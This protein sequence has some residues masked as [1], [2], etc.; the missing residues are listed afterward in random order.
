MARHLSEKAFVDALDGAVDAA[1]RGHLREC[2][3]CAA[4]VR[5][6]EQTLRLASN[7]DV[8]EPSPLY[9]DSLRAQ[10]GRR[11]DEERPAPWWK[12]LWA[13][14]LA[15]AAAAALVMVSLVPR[16]PAPSPAARSLPAWSALPEE[17]DEALTV[18]GGLGPSDEEVE[19]LAGDRG[20]AERIADMTDDESRA[21]V[22]ALRG[23]WAGA[24]R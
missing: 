4:R 11:L 6:M 2:A 7:A 14:G 5:E 18:L 24:R 22:E 16:A 23:D 12:R 17:D 19:S 1:S 15:A 3:V 21:L 9:W 20:V 13:P 8:P 10:I